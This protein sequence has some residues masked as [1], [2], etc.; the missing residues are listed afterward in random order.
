MPGVMRRCLPR[1]SAAFITAALFLVLS[2][3]MISKSA[4]GNLLPRG[5]PDSHVVLRELE[6][7]AGT[8]TFHSPRVPTYRK[9]FS[10]TAGVTSTVVY[11]GVGKLF[12]G[13]PVVPT[14]TMF[15]L[16]PVQRPS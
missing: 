12:A 13:A 15:Q 9:G 11:G 16:E 7:R 6:R 1:A 5:A 14:N 10:R 3:L 8:K 2:A 4:M